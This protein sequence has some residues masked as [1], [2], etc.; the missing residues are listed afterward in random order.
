MLYLEASNNWSTMG[1]CLG[2]C[3]FNL[4]INDVEKVIEC[5]LIKLADDTKLGDKSMP[6]GQGCHSKRARQAGK[7]G[8]QKP[9]RI[10]QTDKKS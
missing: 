8:Q 2:T 10:Q 4:F 9:Y 1:V 7:M 5:M 6:G 3:P